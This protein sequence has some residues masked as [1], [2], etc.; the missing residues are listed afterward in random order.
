MKYGSVIRLTEFSNEHEGFQISTNST[1][2]N[3]FE[4]MNTKENKNDLLNFTIIPSI[5][6]FNMFLKLYKRDELNYE[7]FRSEANDN[8]KYFEKTY[9]KNIKYEEPFQLY[10]NTSHSF[11]TYSKLQKYSQNIEL[12]LE[13]YPSKNSQFSMK[14]A[15][16]TNDTS[17][18]QIKTIDI[19]HISTF[20][21][22]N[23]I[24]NIDYRLK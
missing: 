7:T 20:G 21:L 12:K 15:F 22:S 13:K 14:S 24:F 19:V 1:Y 2:D 16:I 6:H 17:E 11:L 18:Q 4:F 9:G 3:Q 10:N 8:L 23:K 5:V